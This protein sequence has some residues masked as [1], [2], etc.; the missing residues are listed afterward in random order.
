MHHHPQGQRNDLGKML[1]KTNNHRVQ[2]RVRVFR[3]VLGSEQLFE[4]R[5]PWM[6]CGEKQFVLTAE[7]LIKDCF[8]DSGGLRDFSCRCGVSLSAK[9]ASR[10]IKHLVVANRLLASHAA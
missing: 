8:R 3:W 4:V 1:R 2:V 7:T 5:S 6:H 9:N 10:D